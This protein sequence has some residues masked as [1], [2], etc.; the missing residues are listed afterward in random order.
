MVV[1]I[2]ILGVNGGESTEFDGKWL[3]EYDPTRQGRSPDGRPM[4]A[5]VRVVDDP[6]NAMVF[7]TTSEAFQCWQKEDGI[8]DDFK[9][10]RPLTAF[11]VE[12]INEDQ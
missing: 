2:R 6:K 9:P 3:A 4:I 1:R 7:P 8:R 5:H 12:F 10:N 11:S